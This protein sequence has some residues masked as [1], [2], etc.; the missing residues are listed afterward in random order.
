MNNIE[1]TQ[2]LSVA[3]KTAIVTGAGRGI[4]LAIAVGLAA[5]G[6]NVVAVD[7]DQ[8]PLDD[9]VATEEGASIVPFH[10]DVSDS[11]AID[12][13]VAETVDRF[14]GVDVLVNNAGP[15]QSSIRP[16]TEIDQIG[17]EEVTADTYE[18]FLK[19]HVL[20]PFML[21]RAVLPHM[22]ARGWGRIMTVTTSLSIMLRSGRL[23]YGPAKAASE[24]Q[25]SVMAADLDG[26]GITVNVVTPGGAVATRALHRMRPREAW[27]NL[28]P[29]EV[30]VPPVLWLS[31]NASNGVNSRRFVA[32][33]WNP[34]RTIAENIAAAG[35]PIGWPGLQAPSESTQW[36]PVS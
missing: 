1:H 13:L 10:A 14:G 2:D 24:S 30:M 20:G 8:E 25:M 6:A 22:R 27:G 29:A 21:T 9:L 5:A 26:S 31:S 3:G 19:V 11:A 15:T 33:D 4:G 16:Y 23:P 35:A 7:I 18:M 32:A 17:F 28:M 36:S 12:Q 34:D